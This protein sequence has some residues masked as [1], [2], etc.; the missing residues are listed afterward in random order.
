M[1]LRTIDIAVRKV[2]RAF[3]NIE[4]TILLQSEIRQD[5]G[6]EIDLHDSIRVVPGEATRRHATR[7]SI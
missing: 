2:V 5:K 1:G 6:F 4:H 7:C 3:G